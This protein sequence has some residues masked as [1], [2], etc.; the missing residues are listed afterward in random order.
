MEGPKQEQDT[1]KIIAILPIT[2][3]K[4][5]FTKQLQWILSKRKNPHTPQD[6]S[7]NNQKGSRMPQGCS[8]VFVFS[9]LPKQNFSYS[10]HEVPKIFIFKKQHFRILTMYTNFG[11]MPYKNNLTK[12]NFKESDSSR[13]FFWG[14][15]VENLRDK[16]RKARI[17]FRI[18]I[19]GKSPRMGRNYNF[20][21]PAVSQCRKVL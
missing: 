17:T 2:H 16:P 10:F 3:H 18:K 5:Y 9:A 14:G 20:C 19:Y 8:D 4:H 1:S 11:V 12:L 21:R 6:S 15:G 13:L 7:L